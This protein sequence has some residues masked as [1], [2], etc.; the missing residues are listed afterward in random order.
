MGFIDQLLIDKL[1]LAIDDDCG[2]EVLCREAAAVL[3]EAR[4]RISALWAGLLAAR[5]EVER[6]TKENAALRLPAEK[7]GQPG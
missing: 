3:E 7:P 4:D 6:L 1:S 2:N 5:A